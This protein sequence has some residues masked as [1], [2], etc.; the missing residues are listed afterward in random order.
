MA[1]HRPA[2]GCAMVSKTLA[3]VGYEDG[4]ILGYDVTNGRPVSSVFVPSAEME[5]TFNDLIKSMIKSAQKTSRQSMQLR[6]NYARIRSMHYKN[7]LLFTG[8][9]DGFIR[10][11]RL[12][13]IV[14]D[15]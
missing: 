5:Q 8:W 9:R 11:F 13:E 6:P 15:T 3:V 2:V 10:I 14:D 12:A 7:G 4:L 1:R